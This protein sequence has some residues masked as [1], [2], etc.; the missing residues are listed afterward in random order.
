MHLINNPVYQEGSMRL[1]TRVYDTSYPTLTQLFIIVQLLVACSVSCTGPGNEVNNSPRSRVCRSLNI[2]CPAIPPCTNSLLPTT[3]KMW[4][5]RGEGTAPEVVRQNHS[6]GASR[7]C[8]HTIL[9]C[10]IVDDIVSIVKGTLRH[11]YY[12]AIFK[13]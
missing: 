3:A 1:T 12:Y 8:R 9:G 2:S 13:A 6:R 4:P 11:Q 7:L 5:W 10:S